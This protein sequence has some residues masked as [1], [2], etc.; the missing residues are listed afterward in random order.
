MTLRGL[1]PLVDLQADG[2][3]HRCNVE[4]RGGESDGAYLLHLDGFP[5]GGFENHKDG[6]GWEN[7][8]MN[9]DRAMSP[10]DEKVYRAHVEAMRKER[11]AEDR[12]RKAEARE[13]AKKIWEAAPPCIEH[14]YLTK[15]GIKP[16]KVRLAPVGY[17]EGEIV[18]P[19]VDVS[20]KPQ[21]L[22]FIGADGTKQ[23]LPGG[24]KKG[25]YFS[26]GKPADVLYI[27]E[28][29]AT[30]SSIHE[31]TGKAVA[32]AFDAGNLQ[33][34]A[35]ALRAKF[36]GLDLVIC[37]DDDY[38]TDGNPGLTKATEAAQA[39]NGRVVLPLFG[40]NRPEKATDFNDLHQAQGLEAVRRCIEDG[41]GHAPVPPAPPSC[42]GNE[43]NLPGW[44]EP[45][46]LASKVEPEP[47][48]LDA[49]PDCIR[50]AV[51]EVLGFVQ[52]PV[53][54]VASSALAALSLAI[55][56]HHDMKR[57]EKLSGPVGLFLLTIADSGERKSTCDGFFTQEI[58]KYEAEQAEAAKPLLK[59]YRA[60]LDAWE[61]K[62]SGIKDGIRAG[63][64]AGKDTAPLEEKLRDLEL[65][66]PEPPRVPRL[67]YGD[68]TPESLK[69]SLAKVWPSGGVVSSEAGSVFGAH[70]MNKEFIMRNLATFDQLWDGADIATERRSTESFTV[71]GA[72]LT[73]AL[74][75][76][77]ATLRAFLDQSGELARGIGFLARC[78]VAW[79]EST[80]GRRPFRESSDAWPC[81]GTFNRRIASILNCEAPIDEDG[82]LTPA[83]LT[84]TAD[85]KA[86][87][88]AFHDRTER[89][90]R[91]G[92]KFHDVKDV[93]SK[94]ADNAA[95]MAALFH[96]FEGAAGAAV[97]VGSFQAAARIAEWH[98][99][100]ARR[101][102][103][104][105][106]LPSGLA[107]AARLETWVID[108][109]KRN[110]TTRVPN[111][112]I[113]QYGPRGIRAKAQIEDALAV[114]Q[115]LGRAQRVTEGR[116][117]FI[118]VNPALLGSAPV[119]MA[120]LA[121][122]AIQKA[123]EGRDSLRNSQNSQ[124]SNSNPSRAENGNSDVSVKETFKNLNPTTPVLGLVSGADWD[125]SIPVDV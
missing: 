35:Q 82:A 112:E 22:Q 47:Y 72:R 83:M 4:G 9:Q 100:E 5:A 123:P 3:L 60:A 113:Q 53:P 95:R 27:S 49:L 39:V 63:A 30:A 91:D 85:A 46:P 111:M 114:L 88:V 87:W 102:F 2:K 23:F 38:R 71:R 8:R 117:R 118:A 73:I 25:C 76:Q 54:L 13:R 18:V 36:P 80:I 21:T 11:E 75:V 125:S 119:A 79:P 107:D 31:A 15:K 52:A 28:G 106:A 115:E 89:E 16:F 92:G 43:A 109:C 6:H 41:A 58:H 124:N 55:Q 12:K 103:G 94:I 44:P 66:K 61:A 32:V 110:G 59:C 120:N 10:E 116:G 24:K 26:M 108:R 56:A 7:W 33:P 122:P 77:E 99:N 40:E 51:L 86:E 101:F 84:F 90:L 65:D 96:V 29:F 104:E 1:I 42:P 105:L 20:G 14:P 69:W 121:I 68:A 97:G 34:V 64:K 78:L 19:L 57:A 37:A 62:G 48:P 74:Q 45:Q 93:A 67:T 50:A 70:G 17:H 98:L 81:L